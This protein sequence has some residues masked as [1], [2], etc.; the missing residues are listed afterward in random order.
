MLQKTHVPHVKYVIGLLSMGLCF[1]TVATAQAVTLYW[2]APSGGNGTWD[3]N[4]TMNW[5]TTATGPVDSKWTLATDNAVF[6]NAAGNVSIDTGGISVHNIT[7]NVDGYTIQN[8]PSQTDFL[9]LGGTTPTIT[10]TNAT[11]TATINSVLASTVAFNKMGNGTLILSGNNSS[12]LVGVTVNIGSTGD[13]T[14]AVGGGALRVTNSNALGTATI[15]ISGGVNNTGPV[16]NNSRLELDGGV[17]LSNNITLASKKN[18]PEALPPAAVI[19]ASIL[20]YGGNNTLT[21][22]IGIAANG[23]SAIIES[24]AGN[25]LIQGNIVNNANTGTVRNL[26]LRGASGGEVSGTMGPGTAATGVNIWKD[27]AGT[28][29]ISGNNSTNTTT[30]YTMVLNGALRLKNN[31]AL[32]PS[33]S[34]AA[35]T[36]N[37]GSYTG[38]IELD[39]SSSS[40]N[41]ARAIT[42]QGRSDTTNAHLA[43][44]AG[45]NTISGDI[46]LTQVNSTSPNG[47]VYLIQS[48][49]DSLTLTNIK[50]NST[51]AGTRMVNLQGNGVV[52]GVIGGGIA[53]SPNDISII[54]GGTGTWTL[55]GA[56][57]YTGATT[58]NSGTLSLG[59]LG[60]IAGSPSINV[61]NGG[62]F[63]VSGL[64][65]GSYTVGSSTAQK[66]TGVGTVQGGIVNG[67]NGIICP[68]TDGS[69]GTL[70]LQSLTLGSNLSSTVKFDLA[71]NI[72]PGNN[73]LIE[74]TSLSIPG[75]STFTFNMINNQLIPASYKLIHYT[76]AKSGS[77]SSITPSGLGSG[78]TTRQ[79]FNLSESTPNYIELVVGTGAPLSITWKGGLSSNA[80]DHTTLNW[81]NNTEKFYDLDL[82]TFDDSGSNSPNI[83]ITTLVEPGSMT[84]NNTTAKDYKFTGTGSIGG[85]GGMALGGGGKVTLANTGDNNYSGTTQINAGTLQIGDGGANGSIG[86]GNIVNNSALVFDQS[87]NYAT[88][89]TAI[90]SGSGTLEKKGAGTLTL[91]GIGSSYTGAVTISGGTIVMGGADAL[92]TATTAL[93][94]TNGTALDVYG[95]ST[96][97][98]NV[99]VTGAGPDGTSGAI[100]SSATTDQ[101]NAFRYVTLS[102]N[103][104]FGG[105]GR[106]D[107]RNNGGGA[108]TGSGYTLTKVGS[109]LIALVNLGETGLGTIDVK[110]GTLE[111]EGTTTL[112]DPTKTVI[113]E[114]GAMLGMYTNGTNVPNLNKNLVLQ[115]GTLGTSFGSAGTNNTFSGNVTLVGGGILNAAVSTSP[116]ATSGFIVSGSIGGSGVLNKTDT[117][118]TV[119][120]LGTANS[121]NGGTTIGGGTLQ[122]G[123]G[124]ANGSLP[125]LLGTTITNNGTLF[126]NTSNNIN[127]VNTVITTTSSTTGVGNVT[128]NGTG[129]LTL[130]KANS[131]TGT[132]QIGIGGANGFLRIQDSNALGTSAVVIAGLDNTG[133]LE[134][135]GAA[136]TGGGIAISNIISLNSR[137]DTQNPTLAPHILNYSGNNTITSDISCVVGGG[138]QY[139]F[140][141]DAGKLTLQGNVINNSG[142]LN[143]KYVILKG[144]GDGEVQGSITIIYSAP[145]NIV[146]YGSGTW[147]LLGYNDSVGNTAVK[148]GTL[149]LAGSAA[150]YSPVI[151][152]QSGATFDVSGLSAGFTLYGTVP[153]TMT[154]AGTVK[155]NITIQPGVFINPGDNSG[156]GTLTFN[157]GTLTF[158]EGDSININYDINDTGSG[159][160]AD[161]IDVT[162]STGNLAL[163]GTT[164]LNVNPLKVGSGSPYIIAQVTGGGTLSGAGAINVV[165]NNG[166]ANTTRYT[167]T[168]TINTLAKTVTLGVSGSNVL[169]T[170]AGTSEINTWDVKSTPAWTN[171]TD[172][173][174]WNADDASFTDAA[175]FKTVTISG[176][177]YPGSVTVNNSS[178]GNDYTFTGIGKISGGTGLT[179]TGA[180]QLTIDT[181]NDYTGQTKVQAGTLF[182]D[183]GNI[184]PSPVLVTG[185]MLRVGNDGALGDTSVGTTI[186]GGTLDVNNMQL[187]SESITASGVGVIDPITLLPGGAIINGNIAGGSKYNTNNLGNL[188]YV[189]LAG[190]TTFGGNNDPAIGNSGRWDIQGAGAY[191]ST[192]GQAYNL[193][194]VGGNQVSLVGVAVDSKLAA[195][196]I[197]QGILRLES[198]STL[199]DPNKTATVASGAT[200]QFYNQTTPLDKKVLLNGGTIRALN[201]T[202]GTDNTVAGTVTVNGTGTLNASGGASLT[203]N[204]AIGGVGSVIKSGAGTV[205]IVG[206][207]SYDGNTTINAGTLQIN[208]GG[209]VTL[210]AVTGSATSTLGVDNTTNLT[211]DSVQ[212]S[213]LNV[214]AGSTLTIA[215]L[216]GGPLAS[217]GSMSAVPEPSTWAM[218]VMAAMGL[219][220][221]W[222]RSR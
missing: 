215:P 220:I 148:E 77:I 52:S 7:F 31:N 67:N 181:V 25:L 133:R 186:N 162:G 199:G 23:N 127:L 78:G 90:L 194:K 18:V 2:N 33:T 132:T 26:V 20:N 145:M 59:A 116:A 183:S 3:N 136:A 211:V 118:G 21:G 49:T 91:N 121:W 15:N 73:D 141:S 115:G 27:G 35:V 217:P 193:T 144:A 32:G 205:F 174:F 131:Y 167:F 210:H 126:V 104:T 74:V 218:L 219:S 130:G 151:S 22:L 170:W 197:N 47:P 105:S 209:S 208:S 36:V 207:P 88:A 101:Q 102:G 16:L 58:I 125:D 79:S 149:A 128:V 179:K 139:L 216:P 184:G 99:N 17:T 38:R 85:I 107:I 201:N 138:N 221:Y 92:G 41:I 137:L 60:T 165:T 29:T 173:I 153:Q 202:L 129:T 55:S 163:N 62:V 96:G 6:Q 106:W 161:R 189:T 203:I 82:V 12:S 114:S 110:N 50:N 109:N 113:V 168:P 87:G 146:K 43:N 190:D 98:H 86:T 117:A 24:A 53:S 171:S 10:V 157:N 178:P 28:W 14:N 222:R 84:F 108:L 93:T 70:N 63:D 80:W 100:V 57:T 30:A 195:V 97:A 135:D 192:N 124:G 187:A 45:T 191:L 76:G 69:A 164:T 158:S 89:S 8:L 152:V 177:V 9:T 48:N 11:D 68:G 180:G 44:Y 166:V 81:N 176:A 112:G 42:L 40:L 65:G 120:L 206:T 198:T 1:L 156:V 95:N 140:Q 155:G 51:V 182:I 72:L 214:G 200:L 4:I 185:G 188:R 94:I 150:L 83:N 212:V 5:A 34:T 119:T 142:N 147:T 61:N 13:S 143:A 172:T 111:I 103:T 39:G 19:P 213:V 75:A 64:S 37:G 169:N 159:Q 123:N 175:A 71:N 46:L 160:A 122:I 134:L 66:L 204:G 154:G 196:N 56:N 54:K